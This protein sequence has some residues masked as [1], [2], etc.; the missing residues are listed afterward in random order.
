AGEG[1]AG[2]GGAGEGGAGEL[3]VGG[4][5]A[6][7]GGA[8]EGGAGE[9]GAGEGGAGEGGA[10]EGGAGEGGAGEGGAAT[11]DCGSLPL[12]S[13]M[14]PARYPQVIAVG[15]STQWGTLASFSNYGPEMD[16][17]APGQDILSWDIT[18]GDTKK[19]LGS[20]SGT[21]MAA[22]YVTAAVAL[23][24]ALDPTLDTDEIRSILVE[25]ANP[26]F[27]GTGE[28][29]LVAALDEVIDRLPEVDASDLEEKAMEKLYKE[30]LKAKL[31]ALE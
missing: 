31:K 14:Y 27:S 28:I 16:V 18:N 12:F 4:G 25:T 1:G 29:N 5:G 6:G 21:S 23:M 19:G 13:V 7:E 15:A 9:G 3:C 26:S 17:M 24:L 8:G 30:Q 22:P 20:A 2:E 10:G 11:A